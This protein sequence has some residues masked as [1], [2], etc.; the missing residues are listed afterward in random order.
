MMWGRGLTVYLRERSGDGEM[1]GLLIHDTR[2]KGKAITVIA[3]NGHLAEAEAGTRLI[4]FNGDR[5][6]VD[7]ATGHLSQLFFDQYTL[8]LQ[9]FQPQFA[10]HWNEPRE[11]RPDRIDESRHE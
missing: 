10:K 8:D 6:E 9:M 11:R 2:T 5:Q 1:Y 7:R 4:V 3:K